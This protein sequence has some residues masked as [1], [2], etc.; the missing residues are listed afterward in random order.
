MTQHAARAAR[1]I[2]VLLI[3]FGVAQAVLGY[4]LS[5]NLLR[6]FI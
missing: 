2:L 6:G 4:R 5:V 1:A 3:L